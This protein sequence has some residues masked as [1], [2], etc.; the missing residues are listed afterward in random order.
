[1]RTEFFTGTSAG[2]LVPI[3]STDGAQAFAVYP[4]QCFHGKRK[5]D[6]F[7]QNICN[8]QL[9]PRK[10]CGSRIL[11]CQFDLILIEELFV[12]FSEK[13][14]ERFLDDRLR[15]LQT[16]RTTRLHRSG[17]RPYD[18]DFLSRSL[19][20]RR[21]GEWSDLP[22]SLGAEFHNAGFEGTLERHLLMKI[23]KI[24]EILRHPVK[25]AAT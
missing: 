13:K 2:V 21:P 14:I 5:Q 7:A 17:Q 25:L 10:K 6:L 12:P 20:R 8:G 3:R 19:G 1:M 23:L 18:A 9:R 11:F 24:Q 16:S 15:G 4:A 22:N